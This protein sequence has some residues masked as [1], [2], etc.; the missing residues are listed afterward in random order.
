MT[1]AATA[2]IPRQVN[3]LQ[4]VYSL[5]EVLAR[6]GYFTDARGAAQAVVKI[7]AGREMGFPAIASM[8]GIHIVEG[9]PVI[10]SH[11]LAAA[12]RKSGT[13]DFEILEHTDQVCAVR[14]KRRQADGSWKD[15]EPVERLTLEEA[16]EKGWTVTHSGKPKPAWRM[17][18]KNMLFA[19]VISNG[20]KFHCPNL[21][22]G[23]VTYDQDEMELATDVRPTAIVDASYTVNG[24][25]EEQNA[26]PQETLANPTTA[27]QEPDSLTEQEYQELV[28]LARQHKRSQGEVKTICVVLNV[29][30]LNRAPRSR[31]DWLRKA[32]TT[33]LIK[34]AVV[35]RISMLVE[36]LKLSWPALQ[37]KLQDRYQVNSLSHLLPDQAE[38]VEAK[39]QEVL[40]KRQQPAA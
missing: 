19:R 31:L 30:V 36:E 15:L 8:T 13:Y 37:Q 20:Y 4:E 5:A 17:T 25:Y 21:F 18:P 1:Q 3:D 23:L 40:K 26:P 6:S 33:G 7:L 32:L 34:T 22:D 2:L 12:I 16:V 9:K 11:L 29:P 14:F 38:E 24:N 27:P 35:D 10:G 39:L 28:T